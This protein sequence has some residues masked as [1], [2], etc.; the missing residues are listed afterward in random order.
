MTAPDPKDTKRKILKF[1][2]KWKGT[3]GI[4]G[5]H[6]LSKLIGFGEDDFDYYYVCKEFHCWGGYKG[7]IRHSCVGY[8][9][10]LKGR[11]SDDEYKSLESFDINWDMHY[12][13]KND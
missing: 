10:P 11:I 7:I 12:G 13:E 1:I 9:I 8:W 5:C 4:S 3:Y 6:K 2:K